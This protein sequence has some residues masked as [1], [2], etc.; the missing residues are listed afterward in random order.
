MINEFPGIAIVPLNCGFFALGLALL[1]GLVKLEKISGKYKPKIILTC[2]PPFR[3]TYF[4]GKQRVVH[5]RTKSIYEIFSYNLYPGPSAKKGVYGALIHFGEHEG[6]VVNH[7]ATVQVITPYDNKIVIM[8]EGA[9][10]GGKSEM[11]ELIH[12]EAEGAILLG[13]NIITGQKNIFISREHAPF[14]RSPMT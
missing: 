5:Y 1:Q 2:S 4:D 3:H 6:W 10:G 7:C 9:S 8:H 12:R 14:E 13:T 11:N